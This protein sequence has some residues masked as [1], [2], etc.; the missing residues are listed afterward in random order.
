MIYAKFTNPKAGYPS[1]KEK[2]TRLGLVIN[3]E[4]EMQGIS[5]GSHSSTVQLKDF[6]NEFLNSIHFEYYEYR[7]GM[8]YEVDVYSRFYQGPY[9]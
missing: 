9:L 6:P 5:V 3:Q 2:C 1:D 4:Y 7:N 8:K